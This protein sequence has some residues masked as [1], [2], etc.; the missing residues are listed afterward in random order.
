[1]TGIQTQPHSDSDPD[2]KVAESES[3]LKTG[4]ESE[5]NHSDQQHCFL[6]LLIFVL[7]VISYS[8]D[9]VRAFFGLSYARGLLGAGKFDAKVSFIT[10]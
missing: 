6:A 10:F 5:K 1:M 3:C 7:S 9:E 4:S 8:K 2:Y